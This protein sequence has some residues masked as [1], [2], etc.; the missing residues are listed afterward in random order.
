MADG[1]AAA[2]ALDELYPATVALWHAAAEGRLEAVSWREVQRRQTGQMGLLKRLDDDDA[3]RAIRLCCSDQRCLRQVHWLLD[4]GVVA[5]ASGSGP[6][7]CA[8]PCSLLTSFCREVIGWRRGEEV[9]D[10]A[11]LRAFVELAGEA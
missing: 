1:V 11:L 7:P 6:A 8:E 10:G 3:Q 4:E 5:D 2:D 9:A